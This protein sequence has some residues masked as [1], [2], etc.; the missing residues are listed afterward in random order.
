MLSLY[1]PR[2]VCAHGTRVGYGTRASSWQHP[3]DWHCGMYGK[4]RIGQGRPKCPLLARSA[5]RAPD[6]LANLYQ[7]PVGV[8]HIT[9]DLTATVDRRGQKLRATG[10]PLRIDGADVG[11]TDIQEAR[12]R[13]LQAV[14]L[15]HKFYLT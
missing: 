12:G 14:Q 1:K 10:A 7:V 9:A 5:V 3:P 15:W 11:D 6:Q 8:A 2:S 13:A 4:P